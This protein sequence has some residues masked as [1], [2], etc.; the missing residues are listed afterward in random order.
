MNGSVFDFVTGFYPCSL[1]EVFGSHPTLPY[2]AEDWQKQLITKLDDLILL[3]I[4]LVHQHQSIS[5]LKDLLQP[6][7]TRIPTDY[8]ELCHLEH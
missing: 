3:R 8:M 6:G 2:F 7:L 1:I 5:F 4:D